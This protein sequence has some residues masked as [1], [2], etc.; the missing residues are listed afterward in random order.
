M[1][2]QQKKEIAQEIQEMLMEM[3]KKGFKDCEAAAKLAIDAAIVKAILMEREA[4]AIA[5]E[6]GVD[7]NGIKADPLLLKLCLDVVVG[8]A[9]LIR[10]R[11][12]HEQD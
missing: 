3:Y 11:N 9:N 8:C 12:N 10:A 6:T 4:C 7:F 1:N 2:D 5:L